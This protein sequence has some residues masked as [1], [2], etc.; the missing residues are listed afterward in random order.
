MAYTKLRRDTRK[1]N[2][3]DLAWIFM[4]YG[5]GAVALRTLGISQ[6][7]FWKLLSQSKLASRQSLIERISKH[8]IR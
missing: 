5:E 1:Q 4:T 6:S 2:H 3:K 7:S 8:G